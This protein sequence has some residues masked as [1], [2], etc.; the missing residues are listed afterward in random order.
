MQ[1]AL[2]ERGKPTLVEGKLDHHD[3]T[4][5]RERDREL[6]AG[7]RGQLGLVLLVAGGFAYPLC[8]RAI[9]LSDEG[10]LLQQAEEIARGLVLYRDQDSFVAPAV[11]YLLAG[12][13]KLFE[14]NVLVGRLAALV[15]FAA[16]TAVVYALAGSLAGR[17]AAVAATGGLLVLYVWAFPHWTWPLYSQFAVFFSLLGALWVME[18]RGRG[19]STAIAGGA[20]GIA[21]AFKQNYGLYA[22]AALGIGILVGPWLRGEPSAPSRGLRGAACFVAGLT[23]PLLATIGYF[24]THGALWP[25]YDS[26]V[27]HPFRDFLP[28]HKIPYLSPAAL[29]RP[30]RI[31]DRFTYMPTLSWEVPEGPVRHLLD[32]WTILDRGA[33]LLYALPPALF[34]AEGA[35]IGLAVLRGERGVPLAR[36]GTLFLVALALF[37]GVFPRADFAHLANVYQPIVVLAA[38]AV[39]RAL[40]RAP[41]RRIL[42]ALAV[43]ACVSFSAIALWWYPTILRSYS[44][45]T[46]LARASVRLQHQEATALR[47]E[48]GWIARYTGPH[49]AVLTVP[50]LVMLNFLA[51]RPVPSRY[52]NLYPSNIVHDGGAEVL[53]ASDRA[54]VRIAVV[55]FKE[56]PASPVRFRDYAGALWTWLNRKFD[57]LEVTR[58]D[59]FLI[60]G[61]RAADPR[62]PTTAD[63]L[64]TCSPPADDL[65]Q[66]VARGTLFSQLAQ[67]PGATGSP[68]RFLCRVAVPAGAAFETEVVLLP[69]EATPKQKAAVRVT[70]RVATPGDQ[71]TVLHQETIHARGYRAEGWRLPARHALHVDLSPFAGRTVSLELTSEVVWATDP[72]RFMIEWWAPRLV[73]SQ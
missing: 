51:E 25:L 63:L 28:L 10:L 16:M 6:T 22:S 66:S 45:P 69:F 65:A 49:E 27:L 11:W 20:A 15:L 1:C 56:F 29:I 52:Y 39:P 46:G 60:L 19:G 4:D 3:E 33:A 58:R 32:R 42:A 23:V 41:G 30:H 53:A 17:R 68:R 9:V 26:L 62:P 12:L 35:M 48:V 14:P 50:D 13:F 57:I 24:A 71:P 38:T 73:R 43:A 2:V 40:E 47:D 59:R 72:R 21:L 64:E 36:R 31:A 37:L 61:R 8:N 67:V 7:R 55:R 70:A 34:V 18:G 44:T 5:D 54:G